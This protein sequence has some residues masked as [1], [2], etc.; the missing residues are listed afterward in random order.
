LPAAWEAVERAIAGAAG[1]AGADGDAAAL[2]AAMQ[3]LHALLDHCRAA[4]QTVP[5]HLEAHGVSVDLMFSVEQLTARLARIEALLACLLSHEPRRELLR[6]VAGLVRVVHE[7][8]SLRTLFARHY[9]LLAR[10]VAERGAASG[11]HYITRT[12]DEYRDMLKRAAGGGAVLGGTTFLKFGIALLGFTAFWGGFWAGVNYAL[13]FVLIHLLHWTVATKQPAMTAPAMA[14]KLLHIDRDDGLL[15]FVDEVTHL[16]RSQVAG[17]IGNL[18]VV[19]PLVLAVQLLC[20]AAFDA[21]LVGVQDA[22][23]VLHSLSLFGPSLLFAAF[24]G[25]LLFAS[26]MVAGWVENWFVFHR[27]DSGI[28]W[29]PRIVATV[30]QAR[31]QAWS[32]WWRA[33]ISGLTANI[34]LGLMLGLAPALFSFMGL[35]LE[36]RHVTL[37]TGQL[38]A[39]VGALGFGVMAT[40]AFWSCVICIAGIGLLNVGVSFFCAFKVAMRSRGVRL[41]DRKRVYAAIRK[42]LLRQPLSFLIA[43]R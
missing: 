1:A 33:N 4:A 16:V 18:A 23:H 30:G 37:S 43:P 15:D 35:D 13:C 12:R 24:T 17:V 11:E 20:W 6:L 28:A 3:Y 8:R 38:A 14:D 29:N 21:P 34:S 26:S 32:N 39:A 36:V 31:A 27:L 40:W 41:A 2:P 7:R 10:K 42:R 22:D 9:S 5:Q 19:A 25:T